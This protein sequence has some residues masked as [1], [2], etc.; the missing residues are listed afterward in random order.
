MYELPRYPDS[1]AHAIIMVMEETEPDRIL[2]SDFP[3]LRGRPTTRSAD[4]RV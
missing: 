1:R 2:A 4:V 3:L